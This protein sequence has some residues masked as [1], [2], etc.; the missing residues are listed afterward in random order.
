MRKICLFVAY[1]GTRL[2]GWQAQRQRRTVAGELV[3][4]ITAKLGERP[5]LEGASRTDAGVH[6]M[7]QAASFATSTSIPTRKLPIVLNSA[8]GDDVR[9]R[10]AR[11]VDPSFHARFQALGKLYRYTFLVADLVDPFIGRYTTRLRRWPDVDA[12]QSG[13]AALVGEHDFESFRNRSDDEPATTVRR[14]DRVDVRRA[15]SL[16]HIEVLGTAFLYRMVRNIAGTLLDV[17]L[18]RSSPAD[19][20]TILAARD[21]RRAGPTAPPQG[22]CLVRVVFTAAELELARRSPAALGDF[23]ALADFDA[24]ADPA[25][26][27]PELETDSGEFDRRVLG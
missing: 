1:D 27:A 12:M 19:V 23:L 8:L 5:E 7:G 18:G 10:E 11:D 22:L 25:A 13:A 9:V 14:I 4:A 17:G 3:G 2:H 16:L 15:G 26:A 21:R 24:G 6:A 20:A